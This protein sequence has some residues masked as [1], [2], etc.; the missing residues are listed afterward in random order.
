MSIVPHG[1]MVAVAVADLEAVVVLFENLFGLKPA[2]RETVED[3][4]VEVVRFVLAPGAEIHL[5]HPTSPDTAMGR[6]VGEKGRSVHHL[7]VLVDSVSDALAYLSEEGF[8]TVASDPLP[9]AAGREVGFL[10]P[11]STGGL[12]IELLGSRT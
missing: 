7:G 12:L 6:L 3:H 4:A 9:G 8:R 2:S 11:R 1:L 10:H 5:V